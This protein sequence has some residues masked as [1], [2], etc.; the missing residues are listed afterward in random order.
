MSGTTSG[1][2][3]AQSG[4]DTNIRV[5]RGKSLSFDVIWGGSNPIDV[6]GYG[7]LLQIRRLDGVLQLELS[8]ANGKVTIGGDDGRLAFRATPDDTRAVSQVGRWE[9]ELV[10]AE[11]HVYRALSGVATPI[12]EIAE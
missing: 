2:A 9:L 4:E 3:F 1:I 12:E 11:G 7:A 6:T 5:F 8:S 10:D